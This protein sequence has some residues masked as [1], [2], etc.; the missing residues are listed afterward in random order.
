MPQDR[1]LIAPISQGQQTNVKPWLIMDDAFAQ[2][3]NM[4]TWRGSV[5]KR[6]GSRV[7]NGAK[8]IATQQLFTRFR[9]NIGTT[10]AVTGNFGPTVVPGVRWKIGQMFSIGDTIFTVYQANG[11][12][13]TTGA[14]TG[15][16]D[17][18]TGTV[19]ITG[20]TE[21]PSTAIFFYPAEPVMALATYNQA[22][23]NDEQLVGFDTQFAYSYTLSGG[24]VRLGTATWAGTSATSTND[25]Y[26]TTNYRG[27][28]AYNFNLFVTNNVVADQIKYWT[29]AA[30][31]SISPIYNPGNGDVIRT[32]KIVVPFKNRLLLMNT[33]EEITAAGG[34][35]TFVNRVRYSQQGDAIAVDAF[36]EV[37]T[38][39]K[40]GFIDATVNEAI[41]S[42]EFIKDR[43]IVFFEESTWELV[44]TG[45]PSLP[46]A[47]QKINTELGVESMNSVIPFDR[48][49][50]GFGNNG[51]HACNGMNVDRIDQVI[52][53]TIFDV[54]NNNSGPQRVAG[55]RDYW[56]EM[57]YWSY[58]SNSANTSISETFPNRV[59]V[60]D[61][62][63]KTWAYNDDSI[64][65]FGNYQLEK[66][67][68]WADIE[69]EWQ[70]M[71][72][73]WVDPSLQDR[74]KSVIAGNQEGWTFIVDAERNNNC[75]SL[76]ITNISIA[77]NVISLTIID[78]NLPINSYIYIDGIT[79]TLDITDLNDRIYK[80][81]VVSTSVITILAD[82][83]TGVY[84][85]GGFVSRVSEI[86]VLTK[87]YNFYNKAGNNI[88][89]QKV[90][91]Y[92][93]KTSEGQ[94]SVDFLVSASPQSLLLDSALNGAA[95][96]TGILETTPYAL[97]PYEDLQDRFWHPVYFNAVGEN[98][99]LRIFFSEEQIMDQDIAFSDFQINAIMFYVNQTNQY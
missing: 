51:I 29:G 67:L 21:N 56:V 55:I 44:D 10:A 42:C 58:P 24:W 87:Q 93:D 38:R 74:F 79:G 60:Y 28:N 54:Q 84:S 34:D 98:L 25:F 86:E 7:M 13:Y 81:T 39:G 6:F 71:D 17:T 88:A 76:Q 46:F 31:T 66:D 85:G 69:S 19:T 96:G 3:R 89:T 43:L 61:Y 5:K 14:A 62:I 64:T 26:W 9:I 77:A 90:D 97:V 36:Y 52:P 12:M 59:L 18:A 32:C 16:Y 49:A 35:R 11:A 68:T 65:A 91:F 57:S 47:F 37:A 2:L 50:L 80:V 23:I 83:I 94:V 15:T 48:V 75:M 27:A 53:D 73:R 4:Y 72:D 78:H 63:N 95:V 1:F 70:E 45:N 22:A 41:I 20:N 99:Q 33:T 40:G 82:D 8:S 30:W 92:V